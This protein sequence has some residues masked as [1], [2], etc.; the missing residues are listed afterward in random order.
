MNKA[1]FA[2]AAVLVLS[3]T[4]MAGCTEDEGDL[5]ERP[6]AEISVDNVQISNGT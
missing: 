6:I 5:G 2:L 1:V 4:L 3:F